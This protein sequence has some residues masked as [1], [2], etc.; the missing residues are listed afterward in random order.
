MKQRGFGEYVKKKR[1]KLGLTLREFC[2]KNDYDAGNISKIERG[3]M[4]PPQGKELRE[5]YAKALGLK[6][7]TKEWLTFQDYAAVYSGR[8]PSDLLSEEEIVRKLPLL[9]R[10]IRD[11]QLDELQLRELIDTLRKEMA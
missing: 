11:S 1:I 3:L 7:G 8:V 4:P 6:K 2:R 10:T 5:K 9:F